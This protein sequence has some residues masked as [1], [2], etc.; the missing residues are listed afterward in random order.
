MTECNLLGTCGF[1][2]K[3]QEAQDMACRSFIKSF[4]KGEKMDLCKRKEYRAQHGAPPNDDMM[5]T[6]QIIPKSM[7]ES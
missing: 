4:C 5:P 1:F 7:L 2:K 3:Y 6:G